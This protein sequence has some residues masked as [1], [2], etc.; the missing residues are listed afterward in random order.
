MNYVNEMV[1][2]TGRV[3]VEDPVTKSRYLRVILV[4]PF[5]VYLTSVHLVLEIPTLSPKPE[6][7]PGTS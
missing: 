7:I 6:R 3:M 2:S 1:I 5:K 4:E